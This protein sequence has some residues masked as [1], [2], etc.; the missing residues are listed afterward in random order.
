ML[1]DHHNAEHPTASV[2]QRTGFTNKKVHIFTPK[3]RAIE[4]EI[5]I[6]TKTLQENP[7][8]KQP[9]LQAYN[10]SLKNEFRFNF[11]RPLSKTKAH[12]ASSKIFTSFSSSSEACCSNSRKISSV[13]STQKQGGQEKRTIGIAK[14]SLSSTVSSHGYARQLCRQSKVV[15]Q[16]INQSPL[17]PQ[18]LLYLHLE[19]FGAQV[20]LPPHHP[21]SYTNQVAP[22]DYYFPGI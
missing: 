19:Q 18:H 16:L 5:S 22:R 17:P 21:L 8:S 15:K 2:D 12:H 3:K 10:E 6:D 4:D 14:Q 1:S 7:T 9:P 13:I 20:L 11:C